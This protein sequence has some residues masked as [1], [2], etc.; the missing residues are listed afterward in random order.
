MESGGC[1]KIGDEGGKKTGKKHP[2]L[3]C[4]E[5]EVGDVHW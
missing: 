1:N 4:V 5:I 2:Y 3:V